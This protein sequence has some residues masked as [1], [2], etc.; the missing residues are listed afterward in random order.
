MKPSLLSKPEF[1]RT[2]AD[3]QTRWPKNCKLQQ[4]GCFKMEILLKPN[5][6]DHMDTILKSNILNDYPLA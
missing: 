4:V 5:Q 2:H 6:F 1:T 3:P